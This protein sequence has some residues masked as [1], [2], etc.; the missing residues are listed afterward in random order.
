[1][2]KQ[3]SFVSFGDRLAAVLPWQEEAS[4]SLQ[5]FLRSPRACS[6]LHRGNPFA[7]SSLERLMQSDE[8][9]G[10]VSLMGR[11]GKVFL[12]S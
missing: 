1:M 10:P 11:M 5:R 7:T 8:A 9:L 12:S 4:F 3:M 6:W 2:Q